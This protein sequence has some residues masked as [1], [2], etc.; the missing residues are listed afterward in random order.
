M[1]FHL[2]LQMQTSGQ[3]LVNQWYE[4]QQMAFLYNLVQQLPENK[5]V[6]QDM[7]AFIN[8]HGENHI[9]VGSRPKDA[10]ESLNRLETATGIS[11]LARFARNARS[12]NTHWHKPDQK[13]AR[14]LKPTTKVAN[15][16]RENYMT[17]AHT[18]NIAN[19][20]M[21]RVAGTS[22]PATPPMPRRAM[23]KVTR[24]IRPS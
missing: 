23:P 18:R 2:N 4:V 21:G 13:K 9:F 22:W 16:F 14:L 1:T 19:A 24:T 20:D 7:E 17:P 6:W 5:L 12:P 11:S 8:L 15:M 3:V 10:A